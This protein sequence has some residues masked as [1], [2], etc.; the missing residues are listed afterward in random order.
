MTCNITPTYYLFFSTSFVDE[1][2]RYWIVWC[3]I[4]F[5]STLMC[6]VRACVFGFWA[7]G[8][9]NLTCIE[10]KIDTT[11]MVKRMS[12]K[13]QPNE[14]SQN[15]NIQWKILTRKWH[16]RHPFGWNVKIPM[17]TTYVACIAF[18][19]FHWLKVNTFLQITKNSPTIEHDLQKW[20]SKDFTQ[21]LHTMNKKIQCHLSLVH[22]AQNGAD[23][24]FFPS[25][26]S[27]WSN[28]SVHDTHYTIHPD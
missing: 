19:I 7:K 8:A 1:R 11:E 2:K 13:C 23:P 14:L 28:E 6:H 17:V 21:F 12:W 10:K 4:P 25:F 3:A 22:A 15:E 27:V 18:R 26:C 20:K 5:L 24:N 16:G 9:I